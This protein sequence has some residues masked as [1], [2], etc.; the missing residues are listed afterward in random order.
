M[1]TNWS[2]GSFSNFEFSIF[3]DINIKLLYNKNNLASDKTVRNKRRRW[4][5]GWVVIVKRNE[6]KAV[7]R[8]CMKCPF[9]KIITYLNRLH[10]IRSNGRWS[11]ADNDKFC[12]QCDYCCS[13]FSKI[14]I[15]YLLN[16]KI[17]SAVIKICICRISSSLIHFLSYGY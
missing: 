12:N 7:I 9:Q 3:Y 16:S 2:G 17:H 6:R 11:F 1:L 15:N 5:L 14:V 10:T 13:G 4:R 8:W